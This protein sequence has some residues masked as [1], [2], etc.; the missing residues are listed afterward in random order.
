MIAVFITI[1]GGNADIIALWDDEGRSYMQALHFFFGV[2][3][4]LSPLATEPFLA[5]FECVKEKYHNG[6]GMFL[7]VFSI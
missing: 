5:K 3:G 7:R 6:S 2:G 1:S 4:I